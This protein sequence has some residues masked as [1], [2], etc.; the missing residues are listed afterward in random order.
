MIKLA[1]IKKK[2][3]FDLYIGR[4]NTYLGL[5]GSKW[6]NPFPLKREAERERVL[7]Q[8]RDYILTRPDLLADL[9]ELDGKILGCYCF[10]KKCHGSILIELR[11]QQLIADFMTDRTLEDHSYLL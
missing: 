4:A 6:A 2:E 1:N 10:P 3:K 7:Q 8:Y 9:H 11:E 5:P